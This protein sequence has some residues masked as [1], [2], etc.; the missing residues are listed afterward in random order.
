MSKCTEKVTMSSEISWLFHGLSY[1]LLGPL[2]KLRLSPARQVSP[3]VPG[4]CFILF[5]L[6][7]FV[8]NGRGVFRGNSW[9]FRGGRDVK[10]ILAFARLIKATPSE[11]VYINVLGLYSASIKINKTWK[12]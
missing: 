5:V 8:G 10:E 1:C 11:G 9:K 2:I 12:H 6:S 4:K 3:I 7:K